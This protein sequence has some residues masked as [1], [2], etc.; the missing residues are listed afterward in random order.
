M[1]NLAA[2]RDYVREQALIEVDDWAS[3][4]LNTVINEGYLEVSQRFDWP[5]L[6]S[7]NLFGVTADQQAY[8]LASIAAGGEEIATI[9]AI[10][11]VDRRQRLTEIGSNEAFQRFGNDWSTSSRA[12]EFF[13]WANEIN[14][15]PVPDTTEANA[16]KI[17]YFK[18]PTVLASDAAVPEWDEQF[19][20]VLAQWALARVWEREEDYEKGSI[21]QEK[22]EEQVERMARYY[23]DRAVNVPQ[24]VGLRGSPRRGGRAN[25]T[26]FLDG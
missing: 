12:Y 8:T 16:Y 5:W 14:L 24:V 15:I 26:P 2:I 9:Q 21:W 20:Y 19:H 11:D 4:K 17:Y 3:D 10:V 13:I 18:K 6:E 23:L 22:F 25:N 7:S 1:A